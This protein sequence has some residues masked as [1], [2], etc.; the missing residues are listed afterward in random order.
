VA[1][2]TYREAIRRGLEE[3][4]ED[5]RVFL[6]GEDIGAYGGAYA[7]TRGFL[8]KYGEKRIRDM[9]IAE[10]V[11]IGAGVGAAMRG[12]RPI[13]ELMTINF[14]L[15]AMDQIVNMAAKIHYM[16]GGQL[17][18]PMVIR[19]VSGG[20]NMLAAT[21]SQSFE[22]LYAHIPGLRVVAPA[23]P[24]D[25]LG[26]LR[27]AVKENNPVLYVEHSLLYST[28][29]EVPEYE[30]TVPL[31][32]ADVKRPGKDVTLVAYL[33]MVPVALS[34]AERLAQEGID[35]EVVDLRSL[36]PLD[37]ETV[38]ASVRRTGKAVVVEE[39]WEFGGFA[40]EIV[41]L[42]NEQAFDHLDGPVLRVGGANAP[43]PY[44][45]NLELAA[46]PNEDRIIEKVKQLF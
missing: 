33:R 8:E 1:E 25:A 6:M 32:S 5:E 24:Y 21:H 17:S 23:T 20:G 30:F 14:S 7:V 38:V 34:A 41:A 40:G 22:S 35:A 46:I 18:V 19:T 4:L 16:S 2:I 15:L 3:A 28:R 10:S 31:G 11:I 44:A 36:S 29:G 45:R 43:M 27:T 12:L 42:L 9:P 13:V 39:T 26:L 37:G